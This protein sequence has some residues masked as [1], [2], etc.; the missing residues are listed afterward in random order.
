MLP[1]VTARSARMSAAAPAVRAPRTCGA[2]VLAWTRSWWA[3]SGVVARWGFEVMKEP[4]ADTSN[5]PD[6]HGVVSEA[7]VL[8]GHNL[9]ALAEH[10]HDT[11]FL[12]LWSLCTTLPDR[13]RHSPDRDAGGLPTG[14]PFGVSTPRG[15]RPRQHRRQLVSRAAASVLPYSGAGASRSILMVRLVRSAYLG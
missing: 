5:R 11:L 15:H 4:E 12:R 13:L 14:Q 8:G 1:V 9:G 3:C 7:A 6:V 2:R 10:G